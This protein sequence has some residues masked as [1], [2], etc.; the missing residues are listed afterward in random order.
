MIHEEGVQGE[1][2][3]NVI[4]DVYPGKLHPRIAAGLAPLMH[5]QLRALEKTEFEK[6]LARVEWLL[7][8]LDGRELTGVLSQIRPV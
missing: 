4:S 5:L 7:R 3:L 2:Q 6:R 8:R 1:E